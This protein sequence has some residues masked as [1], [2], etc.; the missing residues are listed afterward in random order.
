MAND[1]SQVR[2]G[3]ADYVTG[4]V[5]YGPVMKTVPDDMDAANAATASFKKS[6]Y[7]SEDGL[8]L[9]TDFSTT[10]IGE[11]NGVHSAPGVHV[12]RRLHR[13][14]RAAR[15]E[16]RRDEAARRAHH[17]R[18][19]RAPARASRLGVQHEGR[20]RPHEGARA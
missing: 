4:A 11:M 1:A 17:H 2:V 18:R 15:Q 16:D 5:T 14:R 20:R 10:D 7:V 9:S 13:L 12:R 3:L 8:E 6:G 19:R